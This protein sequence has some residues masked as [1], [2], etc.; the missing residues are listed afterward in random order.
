MNITPAT[1]AVSSAVAAKKTVETPKKEFSIKSDQ[2]DRADRY[3]DSRE[4][5]SGVAGLTTGA[6]LETLDAA[7]KSPKLAWEIAETLLP[8]KTESNDM[9]TSP[10]DWSVVI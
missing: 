4:F 8:Q 3:E 9:V 5:G 7:E 6:T 10:R 2:Y 1:S